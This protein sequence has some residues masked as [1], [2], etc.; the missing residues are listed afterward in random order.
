MVVVLYHLEREEVARIEKSFDL[1][2]G[3]R[4]VMLSS[5]PIGSHGG[6]RGLWGVKTKGGVNKI[7]PG[8]A[9]HPLMQSSALPQKNRSTHDP[10]L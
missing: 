6:V 5:P 10:G 4:V 8:T 2:R 7:I 1:K 3:A 9:I